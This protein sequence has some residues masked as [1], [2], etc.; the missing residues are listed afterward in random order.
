MNAAKLLSLKIISEVKLVHALLVVESTR[1]INDEKLSELRHHLSGCTHSSTCRS[2]DTSTL[3]TV[4]Y[5]ISIN[6]VNHHNSGYDT[7]R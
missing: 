2:D 5:R 4:K 3:A 7:G 1:T 6:I